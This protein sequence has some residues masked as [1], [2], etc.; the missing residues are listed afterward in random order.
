MQATAH[1]QQPTCMHQSAKGN[2]GVPKGRKKKPHTALPR[3]KKAS[4][5]TDNSAPHVPIH[6]V[7]RL[8]ASARTRACGIHAR[9]LSSCGRKRSSSSRRLADTACHTATTGTCRIENHVSFSG[10]VYRVKAAGE[11]VAEVQAINS[12]MFSAGV[13]HQ[14]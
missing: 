5:P 13:D 4:P 1:Q 6:P 9:R 8:F 2:Q 12:T 3:S 7:P 11:G 10:S 14:L